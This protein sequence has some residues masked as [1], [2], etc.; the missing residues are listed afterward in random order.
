MASGKKTSKNR[1]ANYASYQAG[2]VCSKNKKLKLTRHLKAHPTDA[3]AIQAIKSPSYSRKDPNSR[4]WTSVTKNLAVLFKSI[5]GKCPK[6]IFHANPLI[7]S[8]A[9]MKLNSLTKKLPRQ[10]GNL[11][12]LKERVVWA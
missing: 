3:Q 8:A 9:M 7:A 6:D 4:E 1:Q 5:Y 12:S 11:F 2:L 10:G